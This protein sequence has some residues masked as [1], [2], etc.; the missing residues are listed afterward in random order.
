M[1]CRRLCLLPCLLPLL[2]S[3][4]VTAA[5]EAGCSAEGGLGRRAPSEDDAFDDEVV[6]AT[7]ALLQHGVEMQPRRRQTCEMSVLVGNWT[8]DNGRV[9][10]DPPSGYPPS[11]VD[12]EVFQASFNFF[13]VEGRYNVTQI[14]EFVNGETFDLLGFLPTMKLKFSNGKSN[15]FHE[16]AYD[17]STDT[18][19]EDLS[20]VNGKP[21]GGSMAALHRAP[22]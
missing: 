14:E 13:G 8:Y 3:A 4:V 9:T 11:G 2:S 6:L 15:Y 5:G 7:V 19:V 16:G 1:P 22:G 17:Q 21:V 18:L 10:F 20:H 12:C